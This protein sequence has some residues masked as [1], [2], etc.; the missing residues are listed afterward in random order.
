MAPIRSRVSVKMKVM[1][2]IASLLPILHYRICPLTDSYIMWTR[3]HQHPSISSCTCYGSQCIHFKLTYCTSV[4]P[5]ENPDCLIRLDI[6]SGFSLTSIIC[7]EC[8]FVLRKNVL[9][10]NNR[11]VLVAMLSAL[12]A[13]VITSIGIRFTTI[14]TSYVMSGTS[15]Y[16]SS[17]SVRF[18]MPFIPL[19]VFQ[20][21]L[22]SL[23]RICA[24]QSWR[25][26]KGPLYTVLVK[27]NMFYHACGLFLSAVNALH[28]ASA[29]S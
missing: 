10:N 6:Y 18:F 3:P 24:I 4:N 20:L 17:G 2:H 5:T 25:S 12:F 16:W 27:H 22:V 1:I 28:D 7:S 29:F 15:C 19:F 26:T 8:L 14:A 23:T 9:W 11:I 21:G 13:I